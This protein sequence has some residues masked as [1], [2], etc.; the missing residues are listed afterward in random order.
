M[1]GGMGVAVIM[2]HQKRNGTRARSAATLEKISMGDGVAALDAELAAYRQHA[3]RLEADHLGKWVVFKNAALVAV[4][5]SF[6]DA[7]KE[8][9][10]RFGR[11]PYLIRQVG[12]PPVVIPASIA[13]RPRDGKH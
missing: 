2:L 9:T 3:N 10:S 4:H 8:A 11:G 13:Y 12:A 7:A 1:V 5:D 6:D